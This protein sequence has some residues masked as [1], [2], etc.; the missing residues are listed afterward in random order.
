MGDTQ[1]SRAI[2]QVIYLDEYRRSWFKGSSFVIVV[3]KE[4][5]LVTASHCI[6]EMNIKDLFFSKMATDRKL[7]SIPIKNQIKSF[8]VTGTKVDTDL[9][10]LK[11]D[12]EAYNKNVIENAQIKT[13][14][15]YCSE[16]TNNPLFRRLK[17]IY[18]NN[19]VKL[20]KK[21]TQTTLFET[22]YQ[23]QNNQINE[24]I[25]NANTSLAEIKNLELADFCPK[26]KGKDCL[27][28]GYSWT[29]SKIDCDDGG[30]FQHGYQHL[31][32]IGAKLTGK[33][34]DKSSTWSLIYTSDDDMNGVSGGPVIAD[35]KVIG[36]CSFIEKKNKILHFIPVEDIKR[37]LNF[38][39][40][41]EKQ[42]VVT[43]LPK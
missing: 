33:F 36:V 39:F 5:F 15:E 40:Q 19:P 23:K 24:A 7:Y 42:A 1:Y 16:F 14:D 29:K 28:I 26:E 6:D 31:M 13:S 17:R 22:F 3:N 35:G 41:K 2:L 8:D 37:S 27:F 18:K 10:I 30:V 20:M 11:V 9:R 32:I 21:F 38:W 25:K 34:C 12:D 4:I 43:P